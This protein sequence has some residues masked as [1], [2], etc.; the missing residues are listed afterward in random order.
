MNAE[1]LINFFRGKIS[2]IDDLKNLSLNDAKFKKWHAT[3][4][5]TCRRMDGDYAS[6][7]DEISYIPAAWTLDGDNSELFMYSYNDGLLNAKALLEA[8]VEELE[9]WGY[10]NGSEDIVATEKSSST[11]TQQPVVN[12][13]ISQNQTQSQSVSNPINLSMYNEEV[14]EKLKELAK[15]I[16]KPNNSG[17]IAP[18][19]RWLADKSIDALITLLPT[20]IKF[21]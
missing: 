17:K 1:K 2:E 7:F 19:V 15:E 12:F 21:E 9:I 14:Q 13:N 18:I 5:A 8:F 16:R 3:I 10:S 20:V 6:R 4:L 11:N